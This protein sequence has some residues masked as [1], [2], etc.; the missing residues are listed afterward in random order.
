MDLFA[1]ICVHFVHFCFILHICCTIVSTEHGGVDLIGL[2]PNPQD[3]SS[4]V[5]HCCLVH[6]IHKNLS[7]IWVKPC[8]S[9]PACVTSVERK[10]KVNIPLGS[11]I[12]AYVYEGVPITYPTSPHLTLS[13]LTSFIWAECTVVGHSHGKLDR[14][15]AHDTVCPCWDHWPY[16]QFR[17]NVISWDNVRWSVIWTL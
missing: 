7:A 3:L 11:F 1:F 10:D 14:F 6:L 8:S 15:T 2:K 9:T 16:S 13:H 4:V 5:L 17:W 12:I